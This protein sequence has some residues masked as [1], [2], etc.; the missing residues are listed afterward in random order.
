MKYSLTITL[1]FFVLIS[2][3]PKIDLNNFLQGG[4]WCGYSELTGGELCIEFLENEAYLKVKKELFFNSLPYEVRKI[5][6]ESQS[7]TWEFLGEGTLNEFF[8]I[9]RDTVNFKQ[10]GAKEFAKFIRKK[11]YY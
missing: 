11:N 3:R 10:T 9:S 1:L 2:C 5:N 6:E 7:I 4:V 8:I